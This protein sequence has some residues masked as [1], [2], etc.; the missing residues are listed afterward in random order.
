MSTSA[1]ATRSITISPYRARWRPRC[2]AGSTSARA[3]RPRRSRGGRW[4]PP[5]WTPCTSCGPAAW[6]AWSSWPPWSTAPSSPPWRRAPALPPLS[7]KAWNASVFPCLLM[8][9]LRRV[10]SLLGHVDDEGVCIKPGTSAAP[11]SWGFAPGWQN[12]QSLPGASCLSCAGRRV[13]VR[14]P[15]DLC[16]GS[17]H[18]RYSA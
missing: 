2:W 9:A 15:G 11:H 1:D 7:Y 10:N 14:G 4:W 12:P 18:Q 13:H 3:W 8:N 16:A 6:A 17:P 5:A